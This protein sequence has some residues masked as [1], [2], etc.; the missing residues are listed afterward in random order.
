MIMTVSGSAGS[1]SEKIGKSM[2]LNFGMRYV[3]EKELDLRASRETR[4]AESHGE[5]VERLI[6]AE[7]RKGGVVIAHSAGAWLAKEAALK[8]YLKSTQR[9]RAKNRAE[10]EKIPLNLALEKLEE[11]EKE[12]TK[13]LFE[14]YGVDA[15]DL[16]AYDLVLNAD[17]LNE[18][19]ITAVVRKYLE[20]IGG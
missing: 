16:S 18:D 5:K 15:K 6:Q 14:V 9:R 2:A 19:G 17:R 1:G 20:K 10:K 3:S 12:N 8:V 11:E 13:K 7:N 4:T